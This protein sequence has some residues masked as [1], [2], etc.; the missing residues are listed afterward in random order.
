MD[1]G[2]GPTPYGSVGLDQ[3][4]RTLAGGARELRVLLE[5]AGLAERRE[6]HALAR[7]PLEPLGL[8]DA[9]PASAIV[10]AAPKKPRRLISILSFMGRLF[11]LSYIKAAWHG[12]PTS[13]KPFV[14]DS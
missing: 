10:A 11:F 8:L 4:E 14:E 7:Q 12:K 6:P 9:E 5:N 2:V 13:A 1:D 3:L